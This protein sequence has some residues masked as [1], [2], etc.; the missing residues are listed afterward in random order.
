MSMA[1]DSAV[2]RRL[3]ADHPAAVRES[4]WQHLLAAFRIGTRLI[5]MGAACLCHAV[6]PG[7]FESTASRGVT[8]LAREMSK[9]L[10]CEPERGET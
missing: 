6:V 7:L 1:T 5:G 4:Y 2:W 3:F 10:C 9:R 8:Q